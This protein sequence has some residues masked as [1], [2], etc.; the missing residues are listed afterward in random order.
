MTTQE[1]RESPRTNTDIVLEIYGPDGQLVAGVGRLRDLSAKG[2]RFES[3][4]RMEIGQQ[5]RAHIRLDDNSLLDLPS[6]V[7]ASA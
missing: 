6:R 4:L 1:R 3:N 5:V 7:D 2:G